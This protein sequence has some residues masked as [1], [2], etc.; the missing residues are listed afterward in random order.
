MKS[1]PFREGFARATLALSLGFAGC[2]TPQAEPPKTIELR[3]LRRAETS[4]PLAERAARIEQGLFSGF[5]EERLGLVVSH[6]LH[7]ADRSEK[8]PVHL[9]QNAHLLA[10]LAFRF[11]AT[12]DPEDEVR[13]RRIVEGIDALDALNGL[14]GHPPLEVGARGGRL[15]VIN[16]RFGANSYVQLLHAQALGWRLF[17]DPGLKAAIREQA[18]RMLEH[19]RAHGLAVVGRDGRPLPH[20]DA[21]LSRR[22]MGGSDALETMVFVHA[23]V[24]FSEGDPGLEAPWREL[25][26]RMEA[27]YGYA[28]LP[29]VLHL[30]LPFFEA[31][32]VS[33]SWLN[34][35]KLSALVEFTGAMRYRRLLGG[36]AEDYRAQENPYFIGLELLHGPPRT[37]EE[38]ERLRRIAR[39]RLETYPLTNTS[40]ELNNYRRGVYRMAL[41]P[42][43][44]KNRWTARSTRPVPFHDRTGD[45]YLWKRDL[46]LLRGDGGDG[47]GRVYSGVDFFEAYWLLA[48]AGG[49]TVP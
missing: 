29:F 30:R 37:R 19:L 14:D 2:V 9:E 18:L 12:G 42:S 7:F 36:L 46:L 48:H 23:G 6:N 25:R 17:S 41:P 38:R 20:S 26:R 22:L 11:A 39:A 27:D 21:S 15:E 5:Q 4:I 35:I 44:I 24:F 28:R 1:R 3:E 32:T 33:S 8:G 10:G 43:W 31:P 13:A 16:D 40:R 34:L 47:G 49:T 45:R